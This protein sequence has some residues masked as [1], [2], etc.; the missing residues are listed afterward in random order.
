MKAEDILSNMEEAAKRGNNHEFLMSHR[1]FVVS[2]MRALSN[3]PVSQAKLSS[4]LM[5][6]TKELIKLEGGSGLP[7]VNETSIGDISLS[8][9]FSVED[10]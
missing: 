5:S 4:S 10:K 9:T 7:L 6:I 1:I 3:D 8:D 2:Q